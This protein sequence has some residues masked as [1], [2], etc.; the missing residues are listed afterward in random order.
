MTIE[1]YDQ[2]GKRIGTVMLAEESIIGFSYGPDRK[3]VTFSLMRRRTG[4]LIMP[5]PG[6]RVEISAEAANAR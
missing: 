2:N 5:P 3:E 4:E 6:G 1:R